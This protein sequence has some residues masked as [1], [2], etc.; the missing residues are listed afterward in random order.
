MATTRRPRY[1]TQRDRDRE[2]RTASKWASAFNGVTVEKLPHGHDA[3]FLAT[4]SRGKE[5]LVEIKT[6][7]CT[8]TH[9]PTYHVS[10]DKLKR[11]RKSAE[12]AGQDA[13]LVVEWRDRVGY[14]SVKTY[15]D[16]ASLKEGGRW[17]R[18]DRHD[19]EIMAHVPI[20]LFK[21]I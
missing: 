21:F 18:G 7:T 16:N 10:A 4:D 19:V 13:I 2:A 8:S 1:E 5:A 15:L 9:Y 12:A 17:D 3:D 20:R 14:I 6:R 11:L